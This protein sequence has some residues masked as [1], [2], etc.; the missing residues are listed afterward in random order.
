MNNHF[1]LR[2][3]TGFLKYVKK[4]IRKNIP[5]NFSYKRYDEIK[6][7]NPMDIIHPKAFIYKYYN[8]VLQRINSLLCSKN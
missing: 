3:F 4:K 7:H 8:S 6:K 1:R 5:F 2:D